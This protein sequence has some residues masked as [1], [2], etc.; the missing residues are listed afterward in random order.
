MIVK[1][2][3][4]LLRY[5]IIWIRS[6]IRVKLLIVFIISIIAGVG[7]NYVVTEISAKNNTKKV[8]SYRNSYDEYEKHMNKTLKRLTHIENNNSLQIS[9]KTRN[10][11]VFLVNIEGYKYS[12]NYQISGEKI[13]IYEYFRRASDDNVQG[14]YT[15]IAPVQIDGLNLYLIGEG[16]LILSYEEV[17]EYNQYLSVIGLIVFYASFYYLTRVKI[18]QLE[19]LSYGFQEVAEGNLSFRAKVKGRDEISQLATQMNEMMDQ[20]QSSREEEIRLQHSKTELITNVSHDLR[21][22]LTS[23]IG[24]LSLVRDKK[25]LDAKE[26]EEYIDIAHKKAKQL[27]SLVNDLFEFTKLSNRDFPLQR[28]QISI[29]H[30][31]AQLLDEYEPIFASDNI[32]VTKHLV[33]EKSYILGDPQRLVRLFENL[34]RNVLE[35]GAKPG[36]FFISMDNRDENIIIELENDSKSFT[37]EES[38]QLFERFYKRDESRSKG[39]G[40]GLG[41]AISKEIVELHQGKISVQ[42]VDTK[43]RFQIEF[44]RYHSSVKTD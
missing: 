39:R 6:S 16:Q 44:P 15:Y 2:L 26:R 30:L 25:N 7:T 37:E 22:P 36:D 13:D 42:T 32:R 17:H 12:D 43:I 28:E 14:Y 41:L 1:Q 31:I 9:E 27:S 10:L 5:I 40:S 29:F 34:F 11:N 21:T 24:F 23:I 35:H 33:S 3:R 18:K 19:R 20:L 8:Y 4:F 38:K